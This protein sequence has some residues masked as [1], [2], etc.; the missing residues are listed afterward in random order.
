MK[1]FSDLGSLDTLRDATTP[2]PTEI[3]VTSGDTTLHFQGTMTEPL[4]VD[5]LCY[6]I[7]AQ[8]CWPILAHPR[9]L[10]LRSP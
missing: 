4:D 8:E 10:N 7:L 2:F 3:Y 5:W 1:M 6:R 9:S